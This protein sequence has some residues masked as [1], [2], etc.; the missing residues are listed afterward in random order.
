M[1]PYLVNEA[2]GLQEWSWP[3]VGENFNQRHHSHFLPL[4]QFCEFDRDRDPELWKANE[5]AFQGKVDGWLHLEKGANSSHI[6]HGMMNQGQ[7]AARLGR[8]DII[9]EVLSRMTT[10]QYVYPSFM[11]SY[12]PGHK[13]FG[14]DPVGTIP[15]VFNNS[16]VFC[17]EGMLDLIPALPEEWPKGSI[18]GV[19]A[20]G[21]LKIDKLAWDLPAGKIDLA[22][23]SGIEQTITLRLPPSNEIESAK[24]ISG[25]VELNPVSGKTDRRTLSL[26]AGKTSRVQI[27]FKN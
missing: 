14:F 5:I 18:S 8:S 19:P 27:A 16:L 1:P 4:Y 17:W 12:W 15:D 2:G 10:K 9:H 3:G 24:V 25:D 22:L 26:P 20:R 21:Q 11:I 7:C 6:T 13:G 23:T